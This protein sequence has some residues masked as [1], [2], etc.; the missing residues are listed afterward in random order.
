MRGVY[1]AEA[2]ISSLSSAKT[3]MMLTAPSDMCFELLSCS[4]TVTNSPTAA[5]IDMEVVRVT[6]IGSPTGTS[7]TPEKFEE[8]DVAAT[9]TC[10]ANLTAEP[11]AISGVDLDHQGVPNNVGYFWTPLPEER[12]VISP[13]KALALRVVNAPSPAID[14]AIVMR[15][16]EIGG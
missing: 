14:V 8:G 12:P 3:L 15:F 10:L 16:R 5:E 11:T 7:V 6:T 1:A 2:H 9:V 13:S 4:V